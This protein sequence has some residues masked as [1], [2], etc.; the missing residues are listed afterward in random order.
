MRSIPS[1]RPY[2][3][4]IGRR[5]GRLY[6]IAINRQVVGPWSDN[7]LICVQIN[8]LRLRYILWSLLLTVTLI[9]VSIVVILL[10]LSA[11]NKNDVKD[12]QLN[13]VYEMYDAEEINRIV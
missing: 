9:L 11:Q 7:L 3:Y 8:L 13:D 5:G 12:Y 6:N 4:A 2:C 1:V 10:T